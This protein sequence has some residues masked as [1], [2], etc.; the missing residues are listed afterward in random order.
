MSV[1]IHEAL[2]NADYNLNSPMGDN[3][4]IMALAKE[5]LH[6]AVVLIEKGYG[7]EE[8]VEPLIEEFGSVEDVPEKA[9]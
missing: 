7:L 5:Q 6:N 3:P 4:L 8:E 1:S 2:L 9:E